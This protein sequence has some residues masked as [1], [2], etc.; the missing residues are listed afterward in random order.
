MYLPTTA[1]LTSEVG[2][3]TR[4]SMARQ[5]LMSSGL[6]RSPSFSTIRSSSRLAD[7]LVGT[8]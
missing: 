2:L 6:A 1:M 7:R 4:W 3:K 5:S 8:S